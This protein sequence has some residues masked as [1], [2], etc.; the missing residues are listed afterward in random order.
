MKSGH[1]TALALAACLSAALPGAVRNQDL[2]SRVKLLE[3]DLANVRQQLTAMETAQGESAAQLEAFFVAQA[4]AGKALASAVTSAEDDGFA[5][6]M[7]PRAHQAVLDGVR[8]YVTSLEAA[9][10]NKAREAAGQAAQGGAR[11]KDERPKK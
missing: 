9:V 7:N 1:A 5:K 3:T 8:G 11:K 2:E 4:Q 10:P 6:G